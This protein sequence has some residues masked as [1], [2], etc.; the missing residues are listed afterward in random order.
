MVSK[1]VEK[2]ESIY[3]VGNANQIYID[4]PFHFSQ[5]S[6]YNKGW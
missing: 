5:N 1:C 4:I 2:D 6:Y 3:I